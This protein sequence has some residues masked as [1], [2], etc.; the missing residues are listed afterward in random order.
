MSA[1]APTESDSLP[2]HV[3]ACEQR[4]KTLFHRLERI[5]RISLGIAAMVFAGLIKLAFF[6]GPAP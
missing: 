5:E 4:Y 3:A 1:R 6:A 2:V